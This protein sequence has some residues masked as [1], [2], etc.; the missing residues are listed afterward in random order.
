MKFGS[1]GFSE[2]VV[3]SSVRSGK[4]C[5]KG[6]RISVGDVLGYLSIGMSFAELIEDFPKL[7]EEGIRQALG[8]AAARERRISIVP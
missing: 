5:I 7:T 6:T 8:Y 1:Q 3:D 2:I 4:A